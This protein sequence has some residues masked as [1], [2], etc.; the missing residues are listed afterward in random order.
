MFSPLATRKAQGSIQAGMVQEDL[1]VASRIPASRQL[2]GL[3]AHTHSDT[4][5]PT[6]PHLPT[7]PP[8]GPSVYKPSHRARTLPAEEPLSIF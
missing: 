1:K 8:P 2:E 3:K 5:S 6:R 4:P 7:V